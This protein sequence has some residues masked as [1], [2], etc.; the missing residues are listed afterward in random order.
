MIRQ[1]D[2][3]TALPDCR[4]YELV[5]PPQKSGSLIGSVFGGGLP[6]PQIADSGADVMAISLQ[7]LAGTESCAGMRGQE[8]EPYEFARTSQGWVTH[9]LAPP[10]TQ[11]GITT[12]WAAS[13]NTH[14][15]LFSAPSPTEAQTTSMP[16]Q[17]AGHQL[18]SGPCQKTADCSGA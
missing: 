16:A 11:Y 18:K 6:L 17:G 15:T 4:S 12:E 1:Q 14:T 3:S 7:C 10:A 8:G 2:H 9:P 5:T 13:A